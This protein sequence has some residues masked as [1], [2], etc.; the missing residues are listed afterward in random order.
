M[1]IAPLVNVTLEV[2]VDFPI[3]RLEFPVKVWLFIKIDPLDAPPKN[4]SALD[5]ITTLP[6][7]L[8]IVEDGKELPHQ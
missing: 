4:E 7:V 3:R 2:F 1:L 5:S 6:E 8:K